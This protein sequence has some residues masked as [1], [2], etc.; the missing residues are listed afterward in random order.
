MITIVVAEDHR[1]VAEC[2]KRLLADHAGIK[3][4]GEAS[5]GISAVATVKKLNP[6]LLLLDL[7]IPRLN[8]LQVLHQ[9]KDHSTKV[10]VVSMHSDQGRIIE[11]FKHGAAGYVLKDSGSLELIE[12]IETV[13]KGQVFLSPSLRHALLNVVLRCRTSDSGDSYQLLTPR[14]KQV[15]QLAAEGNTATKIAAELQ[16]SA[17]TVETYR[18]GLMKKLGL[19]TQTDLVRYSVRH[20]VVQ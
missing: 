17:R 9:L 15:L 3:V 2:L 4:L 16:L 8:G 14:E 13:A 19:K 1:L 20:H 18:G 11:A 12:A 6:Q 10:L 5:D 7:T